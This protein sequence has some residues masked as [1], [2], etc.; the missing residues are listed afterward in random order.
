ME[1]KSFS[2]EHD[3]FFY[4]LLNEYYYASKIDLPYEKKDGELIFIFPKNPLDDDT[5][6]RIIEEQTLELKYISS[7]K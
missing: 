7:K 4:Q 1:S 5:K 6:K 3:E 2:E